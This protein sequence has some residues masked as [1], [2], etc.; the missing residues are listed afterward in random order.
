MTAY[1]PDDRMMVSP[2]YMAGAGDRFTDAMG[3]LIHLF[4]WPPPH[5]AATGRIRVD[6]PD[7]SVFCDFDPIHPAG[8]WWTIAHREPY[9]GVQFSRDT[10]IEAIAAVTQAL[11]Q[12]L[13]DVRHA[14][15]IPITDMPLDQLAA[16]NDWSLQ[17]GALTSPDWYCRLNT[18]DNSPTEWADVVEF[19][20]A[21]RKGNARANATGN[22]LLG[23]AFLHRSRIPLSEAPID[24][25]TAAEWAALQQELG[26][27]EA[28]EQLEEG[29]TDGCSPR[30][31]RGEIAA[32]QDDFGLAT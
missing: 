15:R 7:G 2:R 17:G 12:L 9:W 8:I 16:L 6:S 4:G 3:P 19:D 26:A 30:T 32:T 25:V 1:A 31:C 27:E 28:A 22:R 14:E 18:R 10:P 13:G 21:I 5:G 23:E 29:V 11:P 20:A 24:H